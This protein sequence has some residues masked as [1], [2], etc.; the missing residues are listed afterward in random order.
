MTAN[1]GSF[2]AT[3]HSHHKTWQTYG[4]FFEFIESGNT[5]AEA[6]SQ[7]AKTIKVIDSKSGSLCSIVAI[8]PPA[9]AIVW[10]L[11]LTSKKGP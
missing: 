6:G 8:G 7:V 11:F 10:P 4:H 3:F 9:S 1:S 5:A 2:M